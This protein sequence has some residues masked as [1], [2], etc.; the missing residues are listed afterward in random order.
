MKKHVIP[1]AL[2]LL[3]TLA[4]LAGFEY[5]FT[6]GKLP[7]GR[8][9]IDN[10]THMTTLAQD[11]EASSLSNK[12]FQINLDASNCTIT[13]VQQL[14]T[15]ESNTLTNVVAL[16]QVSKDAVCSWT[17]L[18]TNT[19]IQSQQTILL[20]EN[21]FMLVFSNAVVALKGEGILVAT[22][23]Y[24]PQNT[25]RED[26]AAYLVQ[27][28]NQTSAADYLGQLNTLLDSLERITLEHCGKPPDGSTILYN[29]HQH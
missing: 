8:W 11:I 17:C 3:T 5:T 13:F 20:L 9:A 25:L 10:P 29:I 21:R 6:R 14:S 1:I 2:L 12:S 24:T 28:T 23:T 16:H 22:N 15:A 4:A 19:V 27:M 7:C 26:I 18:K